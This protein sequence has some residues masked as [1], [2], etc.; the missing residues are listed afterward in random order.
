MRAALGLGP[1]PGKSST[2]GAVG[3]KEMTF[4]PGNGDADEKKQKAVDAEETTIEK[5]MRK[6]REKKAKRKEVALAKRSAADVASIGED[7]A[8]PDADN[9]DL[10]FDDPFFT[11][12]E[13][14]KPTKG[15]QRK[16]ERL[17]K[18]EVREAEAVEK[19]KQKAQ[20]EKVMADGPL[21]GIDHLDH[22]DMNAIAKVEKLKSKKG[23]QIKQKLKALD[24]TGLQDGFKMDLGDDRF[25]A[26]FD[27]HDFAIDPSDPKF[28]ATPGMKMLLEEGRK[29]RSQDTESSSR[30]NKKARRH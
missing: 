26:V 18:R 29:K 11:T 6:E 16:E 24:S 13:P 15:S 3:E 8:Q 21:D 28:K 22:F 2:S 20:L 30:S 25:K 23:K 17:K 5:Y 7:E 1:E 14:A 10:G 9:V 12:D 19:A 27:D 4:I